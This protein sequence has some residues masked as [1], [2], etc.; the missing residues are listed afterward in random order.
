[1]MKLMW[2]FSQGILGT[3]IYR[4]SNPLVVTGGYL[5]G[6]DTRADG[7]IYQYDAVGRLEP[8]ALHLGPDQFNKSAGFFGC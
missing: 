8:A 4:G 5:R 6:R 3:M 1:M 2:G 7:I